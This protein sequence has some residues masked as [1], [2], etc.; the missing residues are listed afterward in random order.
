M[1]ACLPAWKEATG[2]LGNLAIQELHHVMQDWK[3][4]QA[5]VK[6]GGAF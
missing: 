2:V 3:A 6:L 5:L 1:P 4:R